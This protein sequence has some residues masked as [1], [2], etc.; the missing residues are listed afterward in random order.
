MAVWNDKELRRINA[1]DELQIAP[2]AAT[3]TFA[4]PA[5]SGLSATSC[6]R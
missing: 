6:P 2:Y 1:A 3:V 5:L 4:A